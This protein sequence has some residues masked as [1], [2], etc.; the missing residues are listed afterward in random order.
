MSIIPWLFLL[1]SVALSYIIQRVELSALALPLL[2][3]FMVFEINTSGPTFRES[4]MS[5][6]DPE[7]CF[8]VSNDIVEQLKTADANGLQ[9]IDLEVPLTGTANNWPFALYGEKRCAEA[10][11]EHGVISRRITVQFRPSEEFN[12]KYSLPY[13]PS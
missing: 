3:S 9:E 8:L 13:E 10:L 6:I 11:Y 12:K 4:F 5:N 1:V 7:T 2:A